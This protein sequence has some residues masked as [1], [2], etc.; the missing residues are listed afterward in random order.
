MMKSVLEMEAMSRFVR[1]KRKAKELNARPKQ[2]K[3]LMHAL[4]CI[5][6]V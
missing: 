6:D 5:D 4:F 2:N 1:V 3:R